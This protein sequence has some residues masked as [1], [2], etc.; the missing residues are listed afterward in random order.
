MPPWVEYELTE[1]GRE[2]GNALQRLEA[3]GRSHMADPIV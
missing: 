1:K 3:W 2:L